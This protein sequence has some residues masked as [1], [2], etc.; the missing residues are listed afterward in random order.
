MRVV[1]PAAVQPGARG[2]P[3]EPADLAATKAMMACRWVAQGSIISLTLSNPPTH[4]LFGC[5]NQPLHRQRVLDDHHRHQEKTVPAPLVRAIAST[6]QF[7]PHSPPRGSA[8]LHPAPQWPA[9]CPRD[10]VCRAKMR[11]QLRDQLCALLQLPLRG[12]PRRRRRKRRGEGGGDCGRAA[13]PAGEPRDRPQAE[14]R[15]RAAW[16]VG[17]MWLLHGMPLPFKGA[18]FQR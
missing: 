18:A 14:H 2:R 7:H 6:T 9:R 17:V 1:V 4:H 8:L 10:F 15:H 3:D 16:P 5:A 12:T 13:G 11:A